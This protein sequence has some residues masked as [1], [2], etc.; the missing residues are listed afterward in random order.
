MFTEIEALKIEKHAKILLS[1]YHHFGKCKNTFF[2][3]RRKYIGAIPYTDVKAALWEV[4]ISMLKARES[5]YN[6]KQDTETPL[7][8]DISKLERY[9]EFCADIELQNR[10]TNVHGKGSVTYTV[11]KIDYNL[12]SI[13]IDLFKD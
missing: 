5:Y 3:V 12:N 1:Y 13:R 7:P 8:T 10:K 11:S 6:A 9:L 2:R 4:E